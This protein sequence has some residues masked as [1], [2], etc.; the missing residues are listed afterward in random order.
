[1]VLLVPFV[2]RSR[3]AAA[4]NA[5]RRARDAGHHHRQQRIDPL[6]NSGARSAS[7][8][9]GRDATSTSTGARRA[10]PPRSPAP[11]PPSTPPR[12]SGTGATTCT[13]AGR[14]RSRPASRSPRARRRGRRRRGGAAGVP[15][16]ERRRG[17][18]HRV[19]RRQPGV[20]E[21][22]GG[23]PDR[24]RGH[25]PAPPRAV[26]TGR[27]PGRARRRDLLGSRRP[28][29]RRVPLQLRHLL[30]PRRARR[31]WA[32]TEPPTSWSA[33]AAPPFRGQLA[34]ADPT[35]SSTSGKAIEMIVQKQM[36]DARRRAEARG[37]T[38]AAALD[39][40]ATRDGWTE[41][42]RLLAPAGRQ[43]AL[44]H[45]PV[46]QDPARRRV[47]RRGRRDVHRL[48]RAVPGR[49]G[50]R[51]GPPG[52]GR[53]RHRAR[54]DVDQRRSDR[55]AA[56]GA[57]PRA[58]DRVHRVRALRRGPEAVELPPRRARA[59]RSG[60]RCAGCRSSR[61]CTTTRSTRTAPTPTTTRTRQARDFV[62]HRAWTGP[63]YGAL[64]FVV[65]VMCVD[66]ERG[67]AGRVRRP[68]ARR[69][70]ARGDGAVRRRLGGRLRDGRGAAAGRAAVARIRWTRRAGR[71]G[72]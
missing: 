50:G 63:L 10:A 16:V 67:A 29:G 62:Y 72:S 71:S 8:W 19:R 69:L 13:G 57:A 9:R 32:S 48:L 37:V 25:R 54:R 56:R 46:D 2:A 47:G 52:P 11:S 55:A 18:R 4:P 42:M 65:R 20:R 64:A 66:P 49:G 35:K 70:P 17:R 36:A 59:A 23:R 31:G 12:S 27:H 45:R 61:T 33:I 39:A 40:A 51:R 41:A 34:L 3:K 38:D 1:M 28:L 24:R 22:R 30:Q 58:G 5:E 14:P 68:R 21:V 26:R 53:L 6:P 43:R 7:T 15:G 60:T 44:L